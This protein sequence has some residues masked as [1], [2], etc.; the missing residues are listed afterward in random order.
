MA[1]HCSDAGKTPEQ[2]VKDSGLE[3]KGDSDAYTEA[4]IC[5]CKPSGRRFA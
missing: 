4:S 1:K 2:M 3:G 5:C